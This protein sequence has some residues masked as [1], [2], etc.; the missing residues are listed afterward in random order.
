MANSRVEELAERLEGTC[1]SIGDEQ[2][3][4]S[5]DELSAF[6]DLVFCCTGCGWWF[7]VGEAVD[8]NDGDQCT[9]CAEEL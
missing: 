5:T 2:D 8:T 9:H 6:D 4:W 7:E 3:D 1:E